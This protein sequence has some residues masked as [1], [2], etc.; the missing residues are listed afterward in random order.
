MFSILKIVKYFKNS[1][2][3]RNNFCTNIIYELKKYP[4]EKKTSYLNE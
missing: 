4:C 1:N 3:K 2:M